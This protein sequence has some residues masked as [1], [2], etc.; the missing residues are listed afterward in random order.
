M[1][2][3]KP[4]GVCVVGYGMGQWHCNAIKQVD[5]LRL[6]AV[7][8]LDK[9]RLQQAV[10][11]HAVKGYAHLKDA[12]ADRKVKVIVLATPHDTHAPLSIQA[13]EAGK[14]LVVEKVM[15]HTVDGADAMIA[16]RDRNKVL[17]TV[18]HNRRW[19][20]DYLT[21][22]SVLQKGWLGDIVE[23]QSCVGGYGKPGGW[24]AARKHG[25]G[26]IYDWGSHLFDQLLQ[27]FG[28]PAWV[29]CRMRFGGFEGEDYDVETHSHT[30]VGFERGVTAF[31][32]LSHFWQQPR[33]R[34]R[35]LGTKGTLVKQS[36]DPN[37]RAKVSTDLNGMRA[38][39]EVETVRGDW[40][41]FYRNLV[42][43]LQGETELAVKP[44]EARE[45]VQVITAALK[46]AETGKVVSL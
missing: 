24:R 27:L 25:G 23:V 17:L 43:A 30:V 15:A 19:D 40:L 9:K 18:F 38:E 45:V 16:A 29:F 31:V 3:A 39:I 13:M 37:E 11:D 4:F 6:V 36:F 12:L 1:A 33:P 42:A 7:C 46:S 21:V 44:E 22:K 20:S 34:W 2:V 8:E 10:R 26:M 28:K 35:I 41:D 32:E 14:H 5:G